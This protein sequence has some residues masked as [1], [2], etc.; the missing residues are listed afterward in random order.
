MIFNNMTE[1]QWIEW[2]KKVDAAMNTDIKEYHALLALL[3]EVSNDR[4][5]NQQFEWG[6]PA[7]YISRLKNVLS[8]L[9]SLAKYPKLIDTPQLQNKKY[10]AEIPLRPETQLP[11]AEPA[12]PVSPPD[13]PPK[14]NRWLKFDTYKDQL[15]PALKIEGE[16][17]SD[18]F[19]QRRYYHDLMKNQSKEGVNPKEIA[20]TVENLKQANARIEDYF[21]RVEAFMNGSDQPDQTEQDELR[22]RANGKPSGSFTKEEIEQMMSYSPEFAGA[23]RI[24]RMEA[25]R[26]YLSRTDLKNPK[27]PDEIL[28]RFRELK[29]WGVDVAQYEPVVAL[30]ENKK[31]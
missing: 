4:S 7:R 25:N 3:L 14:W 10:F 20:K 22:L 30:L 19:T 6:D 27:D 17:L 5:I 2:K 15:S 28:L 29:D 8:R 23:C 9:K 12:Q 18:L 31:I 21:D 1:K 16:G 11:D 24:K 13:T 26:K